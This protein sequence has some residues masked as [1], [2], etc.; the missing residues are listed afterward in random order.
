MS[1]VSRMYYSRDTFKSCMQK[2]Q[3]QKER[4]DFDCREKRDLK[5][6]RVYLSTKSCD[7]YVNY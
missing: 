6:P 2:S 5:N 4:N 3:S 7:N 1:L